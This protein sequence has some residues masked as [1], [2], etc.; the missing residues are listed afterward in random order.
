M[1]RLVPIPVPYPTGRTEK[2][3]LVGFCQNPTCLVDGERFE[4][5]VNHFPVTCPKCGADRAPYVGVLA[6][7]HLLVQ[8]PQGKVR[9]AGGVRYRVAC[10]AGR[11]H[12][13]TP[14][15]QEAMTG[16]PTACNCPGCLKVATDLNLILPVH[17]YMLVAG[18]KDENFKG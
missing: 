17:G 12:L 13:A 15:N 1:S 4:F 14:T 8:D 5:N 3:P 18:D 9:G 16:D 10:E 6:L 11:A 2:Q 7:V